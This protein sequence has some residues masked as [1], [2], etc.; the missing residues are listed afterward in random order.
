ML[1][2]ETCELADYSD[3][4]DSINFDDV[5][6]WGIEKKTFENRYISLKDK[7]LRL[8]N[9]MLESKAIPANMFKNT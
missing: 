9:I 4:A 2:W 6:E 1:K 7:K 8:K 3:E 5:L